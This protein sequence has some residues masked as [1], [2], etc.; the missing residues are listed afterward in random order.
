MTEFTKKITEKRTALAEREAAVRYAN[1]QKQRADQAET[2]VDR[3]RALHQPTGVVAAAEHGNPPDCTT[4][5]HNCWPCPTI[6]ALDRE[7]PE[8]TSAGPVVGGRG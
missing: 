5:G 2:A 8:A 4:C 1:E 7:A 6:R 3:V